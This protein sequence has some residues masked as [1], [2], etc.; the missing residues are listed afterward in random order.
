MRAVASSA[1]ILIVLL[2][3]VLS[4]AQSGDTFNV[5]PR[6]PILADP[7]T[8]DTD[9]VRCFDHVLRDAINA[10]QAYQI[11]YAERWRQEVECQARA[12]RIPELEACWTFVLQARPLIEQAGNAYETA[13][14]RLAPESAQLVQQGNRLM[15]QAGELLAQARRCFQPILAKWQRAGGRHAGMDPRSTQERQP[16]PIPEPRRPAVLEGCVSLTE[17]AQAAAE[18]IAAGNSGPEVFNPLNRAQ[19]CLPPS[20]PRPIECWGMMVDAAS[21][22]RTDPNLATAR[23]GE[24]ADCYAGRE[25]AASGLA[26]ADIFAG[27]IIEALEYLYGADAIDRLSKP[28]SHASNIKAGVQL[29]IEEY[30][31]GAA[32]G[33]I[34]ARLTKGQLNNFV[35]GLGQRIMEDLFPNSIPQ[36]VIKEVPGRKVDLLD[37]ISKIVREIKMGSPNANSAFIKQQV[38]KDA[39]L[40]RLGYTVE[41]WNLKS[42]FGNQAFSADLVQALQNAGIRAISHI[43]P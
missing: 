32:L 21:K 9:P 36:A 41:W 23:A 35:G 19:Q 31:A 2:S 6:G 4:V 26:Q 37:P 10:T 5:N 34:V 43:D 27:R 3:P 11:V 16:P 39:E 13:R 42:P 8:D 22:T 14:R 40:V 15:R 28:R 7:R 17:A 12:P 18:K 30:L 20:T 29:A 1:A 25:P 38:A 33:V 24:A